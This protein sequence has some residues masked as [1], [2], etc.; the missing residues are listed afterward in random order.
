MTVKA[1]AGDTGVDVHLDPHECEL[2]VQLARDAAAAPYPT[3][4]APATYF[5]VSLRLGQQIDRALQVR[6]RAG[7]DRAG[8]AQQMVSL[9]LGDR[10]V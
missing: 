9:I 1:I 7:A 6:A 4:D 8:L 10:G 3:D 5:A 2:L